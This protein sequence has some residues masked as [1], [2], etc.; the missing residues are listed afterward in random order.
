MIFFFHCIFH[1]EIDNDSKLFKQKC[2]SLHGVIFNP[3]K[4]IPFVKVSQVLNLQAKFLEVVSATSR[5]MKSF[6]VNDISER[7]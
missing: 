6:A 7:W 2:I 1:A 5:N 4:N 3:Q